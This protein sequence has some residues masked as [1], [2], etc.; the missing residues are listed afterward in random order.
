MS[1]FHQLL[2]PPRSIV[3]LVL[4]ILLFGSGM[5]WGQDRYYADSLK[6]VYLEGSFEGR[7]KLEL[8]RNLAEHHPDGEEILLFA[9]ELVEYAQELEDPAYLIAGHLQKGHALRLQGEL[10][11]ALE[12][13]FEAARL[14]QKE[15]FT[16]ELGKVNIAIADVYSVLENHGRSVTHY[17]EGI[18]FLRAEKDSVSL[19]TALLNL[20]D[21]YFNQE[22]LD[23]AL[24]LF[25]ESGRLFDAL[26]YEIGV[27]YN[28]GNTGLVHAQLENSRQAEDNLTKAVDLLTDLGDFYPICV[29]Y[30]YMSDIYMGREDF[31]SAR[32][33]ARRSL[34]IAQGRG[35]KEQIRDANLK[36]SELHERSGNPIEAL[37]YYK[38]YVAYRDSL[39]NVNAVQE[40]ANLRADYQISQKQIEVDL[41]NGQKRYQ[42]L[43]VISVSIAFILIGLL[44]FGLFRRNRFIKN[45]TTI[46]EAEKNR[47]DHLLQNILPEETAMELKD[48]GRVKAKK[49][50][51][52]S[53]M[54]ADFQ[55]FT[56]FAEHLPPEQLVETVDFY[57]SK[58]DEIME[59]YDLEKIKTLGD[60]YMAAG[61]LPF[62]SQDHALKMVLAAFDIL[63]FV[64]QTK[65]NGPSNKV[66]LD[67]RIGINSGPIVAGVVG[68]K[69]FAY[70]IWGDTVN[71]AARM[72]SYSTI[73]KINV[74]ENT[75]QLIKE[76][77][78][79]EYRGEIQVKKRGDMNMYYVKGQKEKS[80]MAFPKITDDHRITK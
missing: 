15:D 66:H 78:D 70:D 37:R 29:Y 6:A 47:S 41:L 24:L 10:S 32:A 49:F 74:S 57:F 14:A 1:S 13:Y 46:I 68:I 30:L 51:S 63:S 31:E 44:A 25:E 52:V 80:S 36:L 16:H 61:G 33:Y 62:P 48:N 58:F 8:L 73:G 22:K 12:S 79:C 64:E 27:A 42:R 60:A 28:L 59:K 39:V 5:L 55:D 67:I 35:L 69:K 53:V 71:I 38:D 54:F 23:S 19:A 77:F 2:F 72:E 3:T 21:E 17:R 9:Q 76:H 18:D 11:P 40:M 65:A 43:I 20:G 7:E 75:Y 34:A 50:D 26:D 56:S 4:A 45:A